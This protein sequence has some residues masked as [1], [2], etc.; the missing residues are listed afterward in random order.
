MLSAT[1]VVAVAMPFGASAASATAPGRNGAVAFVRDGNI[2]VL[3]GAEPGAPVRQLTAGGEAAR[4]KWS[5]DGTRIAFVQNGDIEVVAA[6]GSGRKRLTAGAG[7]SGPAWSPDGRQVAYYGKTG[8]MRVGV[9]GS[10]PQH[11]ALPEPWFGAGFTG[12]SPAAKAKAKAARDE[13]ETGPWY[14]VND[15]AL[16]WS[17]D[18]KKVSVWWGDDECAIRDQC[19]VSVNLETG[20]YTPFASGDTGDTLGAIEYSPDS[21]RVSYSFQSDRW[22]E[23]EPVRVNS[24]DITDWLPRDGKPIGGP[25]QWAAVPSP[26]GTRTVLVGR[27]SG[28]PTLYFGDADGANQIKSVTGDQP[29]WQPLP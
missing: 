10:A 13:V 5:P 18:G 17:P 1:A 29:S 3:D 23:G 11:W 26:D 15:R 4:P 12:T 21:R 14:L 22:T 7:A 24:A 16:A 8:L 27:D 6:D 9:D 19:A 25:G 28:V 2:L 20:V